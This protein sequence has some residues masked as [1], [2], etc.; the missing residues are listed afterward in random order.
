MNNACYVKTTEK[1][2]KKKKEM[3]KFLTQTQKEMN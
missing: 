3:S 1:K 2:K